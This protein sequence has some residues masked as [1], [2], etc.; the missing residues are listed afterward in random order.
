[1][2]FGQSRVRVAA[3]HRPRPPCLPTVSPCRLFFH[4]TH[5]HSVH[6]SRAER[7]PSA[8]LALRSRLPQGQR[9]KLF[10]GVKPA[11]VGQPQNPKQRSSQRPTPETA[12]HFEGLDV[13]SGPVGPLHPGQR[14]KV[15]MASGHELHMKVHHGQGPKVHLASGRN[16]P[17]Q[18]WPAS[19]HV[20]WPGP[21]A[22]D[23]VM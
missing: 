4:H 3:T 21:N 16:L 2:F 11:K 17:L 7:E 1:M 23:G 18:A 10:L 20:M 12:T 8:R 6:H 15:H 14:P 9:P 5:K 13:R 22:T 19:R